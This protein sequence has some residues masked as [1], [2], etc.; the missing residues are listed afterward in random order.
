MKNQIKNTIL[1]LAILCLSII[2][3]TKP[4]STTTLTAGKC[5]ISAD[6]SGAISSSYSSNPIGSTVAKNGFY[7]L[8]S[9]NASA[10]SQEQFQLYIPLDVTA[11]TTYKFS[12]VGTSS[13]WSGV[14]SKNNALAGSVQGWAA[15]GGDNLSFEVTVT[16]ATSTDLEGTFKG[17]MTEDTN[18][19]KVTVSNGK[20][21]AKL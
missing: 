11:G 2:G 18:N 4:S 14:Y 16:K 13:L 5:S 10:S 12:T 20:F 21:S 3:C 17:E 7:F 19:T 9:S 1:P 15:S 8:A 6:I